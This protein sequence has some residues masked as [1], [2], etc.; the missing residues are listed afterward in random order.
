MKQIDN[1]IVEK[2]HLDKNTKLPKV[3]TKKEL[4][5]AILWSGQIT[6]KLALGKDKKNYP[7]YKGLGMHE[8]KIIYGLHALKTGH[9]Y[10][11]FDFDENSNECGYYPNWYDYLTDE[12][13]IA[14]YK[15]TG[16]EKNK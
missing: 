5:E 16:Y 3:P 9:I 2:L 1:Y 8:G 12:Q 14:F 11:Y 6:S 13:K 7:I 10:M 15:A 4:E